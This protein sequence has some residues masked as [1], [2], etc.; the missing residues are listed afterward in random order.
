MTFTRNL[1]RR[2]KRTFRPRVSGP[3]LTNVFDQSRDQRRP[4]GLVIRPEPLPRLAVEILVE[5]HPFAPV[6]IVRE[7]PFFAERGPAGELPRDLR[8]RLLSLAAGRKLDREA[9]AVEKWS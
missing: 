4:T 1:A 2:A 7:S 6:R 3:L 9:I 8:E 5:P